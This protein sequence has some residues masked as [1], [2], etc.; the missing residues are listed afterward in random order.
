MKRSPRIGIIGGGIGGVAL[1]RSLD[2]KGI[3]YHI[4]EKSAAFGEVGAGVQMTPN[5]VKAL[6]ALGL[7]ADLERTGF[8]P[9]A[10]VGRSWD[11]AS[12]LFYTPL[13][14]TCPRLFGAEFYHIHRADLHAMLAKDIAPS[15]T[16]FNA[17][18]TAVREE[19]DR[20]I[21]T[22]ANGETFE[23]DLIV[24]ADGVRSVVR[25]ALWGPEPAHYT[26]HMCWR[27]LVEVDEHP[28]P[29]ASPDASFWLGPKGHV[30]TYYVKS[31]S[32]LNVV[33]IA[34]N[35]DWVEESWSVKSTQKE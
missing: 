22:F 24:G 10:M 5:A 7:T 18:C 12:G 33:A 19:G 9:E 17:T 30:V 13:K 21:A 6:R 34:E 32:Q 8:L 15:R 14:S 35:A 1:A 28:L 25:D 2:R 16:T 4:F 26:G 27:A 20:A 11:D 3:D 31:G 23:A 29:F